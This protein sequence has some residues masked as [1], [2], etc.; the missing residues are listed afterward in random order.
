MY[1]SIFLTS[2]YKILVVA[3]WVEKANKTNIVITKF[4]FAEYWIFEI[5][6]KNINKPKIPK[7]ENGGIEEEM[8]NKV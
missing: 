2:I 6:D 5:K 8:A 3:N 4:E 1:S 7:H